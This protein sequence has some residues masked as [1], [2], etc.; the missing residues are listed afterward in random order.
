M[1]EL[2]FQL[3]GMAALTAY[4]GLLQLKLFLSLRYQAQEPQSLPIEGKT[5]ILQ[6]I[7][8]GD[9]LLEE[10]L[11]SNLDIAPDWV[12]FFW[13]IDENDNGARQI[14]ETLIKEGNASVQ[15]I[16]C[17][18]VPPQINPKTFKLGIGLTQVNTPYIGVLDDDTRM[19]A[20]T[21][22]HGLARLQEGDIFTGLPYYLNGPTRWSELTAHFV[23][24]NSIL[25]YLPLLAFMRPISLNGMFYLMPTKT[26]HQVGGFEPILPYL[27]DDYALARMLTLNRSRIVQGTTPVA[28]QTCVADAKAYVGLM[29]RWFV[30]AQVLVFDQTMGTQAL[31]MLFLGAPPILLWIGL[32][33]LASSYFG[34]LWLLAVLIVRHMTIRSLHHQIF[35]REIDF[36]FWMSIASEL[37]QPIHLVHALL[38]KRIRWRNRVIQVAADGKFFYRQ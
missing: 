7:L 19:E 22:G 18:A 6:P 10:M 20:D 8:S 1:T 16:L 11:R 4:L 2:P 31:L 13:L 12:D 27:C 5:T 25:T 3:I 32:V 14:A 21:L 29:H 17:P 28:I 38:D 36:S 24:N 35:Q 30:F 15:V 26:L 23:N 37:L 34:M 33:S 9:P